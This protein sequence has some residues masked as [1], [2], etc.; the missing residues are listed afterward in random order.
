MRPTCSHL[1]TI[2]VDRC[3]V[4]AE[5]PDRWCCSYADCESSE[6]AR[7]CLT[8]GC[9]FCEEHC[10]DHAKQKSTGRRSKPHSWFLQLNADARNLLCASCDALIDCTDTRKTRR[11]SA[12]LTGISNQSA[13]WETSPLKGD[14]D[15]GDSEVILFPADWGSQEH[16]SRLDAIIS[17]GNALQKVR[18]LDPDFGD[19]E[20]EDDYVAEEVVVDDDTASDAKDASTVIHSDVN[21]SSSKEGEKAQA[22]NRLDGP[23]GLT[24]DDIFAKLARE[25]TSV[26]SRERHEVEDNRKSTFPMPTCT[27]ASTTASSSTK[28]S[29]PSIP[30]SSHS[31]DTLKR[32]R[33]GKYDE[34]EVDGTVERPKTNQG[35]MP[36]IEE[37]DEGLPALKRRRI[38]TSASDTQSSTH[39]SN[40]VCAA[41]LASAEAATALSN[42]TSSLLD[43]DG[44]PPSSLGLVRKPSLALQLSLASS[45]IDAN[46][47]E[48]TQ[49]SD[50]SG[51]RKRRSH[52]LHNNADLDIAEE[53]GEDDVPGRKRRMYEDERDDDQSLPSRGRGS[54]HSPQSYGGPMRDVIATT[55]VPAIGSDESDRDIPHQA[56]DN[57]DESE[58]SDEIQVIVKGGEDMIADPAA[59]A[60]TALNT[61]RVDQ[62]FEMYT[63]MTTRMESKENQ[64][65]G[66]HHLSI[67]DN[68]GLG[69]RKPKGTSREKGGKQGDTDTK[70]SIKGPMSTRMSESDSEIDETPLAQPSLQRRDTVMFESNTVSDATRARTLRRGTRN[71]HDVSWLRFLSPEAAKR[72]ERMD[73]LYTALFRWKYG[74]IVRTFGIWRDWVK[75]RKAE[76]D[77]SLAMMDQGYD[78]TQIS[79][80][81][82]EP[83]GRASERKVRDTDGF[84]KPL[85]RGMEEKAQRQVNEAERRDKGVGLADEDSQT[86]DWRVIEAEGKSGKPFREEPLS[87]ARSVQANLFRTR[88]ICGLRNL[89]NTCYLNAVLQALS[90]ADVVRAYFLAHIG[91]SDLVTSGTDQNPSDESMLEDSRR[92]YTRGSPRSRKLVRG[93]DDRDGET[94]DIDSHNIF[95]E[96]QVPTHRLDSNC[97]WNVQPP[98]PPQ[99]SAKSSQRRTK[100]TD[101]TDKGLTQRQSA[102]RRSDDN[103]DKPGVRRGKKDTIMEDEGETETSSTTEPSLSEGIAQLLHV[104]SDIGSYMHSI[105]CSCFYINI[106]HTLLLHCPSPCGYLYTYL[107]L[108]F[109]SHIVD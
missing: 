23:R 7:L 27:T 103:V 43:D 14:N 17:V 89:G 74:A 72:R 60:A 92:N 8:C 5:N 84:D 20:D 85:K 48:E 80:T 38:G 2:N 34:D 102:P 12:R 26:T 90:H 86:D 104:S 22:L 100:T 42:F 33:R 68:E 15:D 61:E 25:S 3:L 76:R 37:Y 105:T 21:S 65:I 67:D 24:T 101:V 96:I 36:L 52:R 94:V 54:I 16:A 71:K 99:W 83:K 28:V 58:D 9:S 64:R 75:T 47:T 73:M 51:V 13:H 107:P 98:L 69:V 56:T 63:E 4:T 82:A 106:R 59:A 88:G 78:R 35:R 109:L 1:P 77:G 30:V 32:R 46:E 97:C 87:S 93:T 95:G 39:P 10:G 31:S 45:V 81:R 91:E 70:A 49:S 19:D 40:D 18:M 57:N 79:Q 50:R 108:T 29:T 53:S 66:T 11:R 62:L 55:A 41:T 44:A 6:I